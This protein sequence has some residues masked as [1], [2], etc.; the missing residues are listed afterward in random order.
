MKKELSDLESFWY[1]LANI[2]TLGIPF[3]W[4]VVVKKALIETRE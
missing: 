1:V 2:M 3:L 4:K